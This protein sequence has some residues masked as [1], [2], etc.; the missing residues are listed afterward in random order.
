MFKTSPIPSGRS[1]A[2]GWQRRVPGG[3]A[4]RANVSRRQTSLTSARIVSGADREPS[5][6]GMPTAR[7]FF[8]RPRRIILGQVNRERER[9]GFCLLSM[10]RRTQ[11]LLVRTIPEQG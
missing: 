8:I 7:V 9:L 6:E 1:D 3:G 2:H 11:T 4:E 10:A 5:V